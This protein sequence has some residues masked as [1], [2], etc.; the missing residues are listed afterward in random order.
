MGHIKLNSQLTIARINK[1]QAL[2]TNSVL[3]GEGKGHW[4][5]DTRASNHMTFHSNWMTD[6]RLHAKDRSV[7]VG[8]GN[9]IYAYAYIEAY[10]Y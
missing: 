3:L 2:I 4:L 7:T 6:F 1:A 10:N 9:I 8:N 5:G